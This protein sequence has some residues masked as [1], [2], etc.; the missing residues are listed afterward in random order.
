MKLEI[1]VQWHNLLE[2]SGWLNICL[3]QQQLV[4]IQ[5]FEYIWVYKAWCNASQWY[6]LYRAINNNDNRLHLIG[7]FR[8]AVL[9][10]MAHFL[11]HLNRWPTSIQLL[12]A[13]LSLSVSFSPL[14]HSNLCH[15]LIPPMRLRSLSNSIAVDLMA[16]EKIEDTDNLTCY[17]T[18]AV[19]FNCVSCNDSFKP[20]PHREE[21]S[22]FGRRK[23]M[24]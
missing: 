21:A 9:W 10:I 13:P 6:R 4:N 16:T 17:A 23:K 3:Q 22:L 11:F 24:K 7:V 12:L 15:L 5:T 19:S 8:E 20:E 14:V 1:N 18:D 2:S